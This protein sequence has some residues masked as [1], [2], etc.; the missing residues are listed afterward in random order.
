MSSTID[1]YRVAPGWNVALV[2]LSIIVPQPRGDPLEPVE[3]KY[4]LTGA[5]YDE[6]YVMQLYWDVI[7]TENQ[8]VTLITQFGLGGST[9]F[10]PVTVYGRNDV[11]TFTRFNG[12]AQRPEGTR[13]VKRSG[14]FIRDVIMRIT[15]LRTP[16]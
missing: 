12:V 9:L 2:T 15:H 14:F 4:G 11:F 13:D 6:G 5:V 10:A 8:Y 7:E 16:S 1:T 3:R